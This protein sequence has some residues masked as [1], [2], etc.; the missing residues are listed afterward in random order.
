MTHNF[1][2]HNAQDNHNSSF[3]DAN[4]S[5]HYPTTNE[6]IDAIFGKLAHQKTDFI[7]W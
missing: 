7:E 1:Y 3:T 4:F 2:E 6:T 5:Q